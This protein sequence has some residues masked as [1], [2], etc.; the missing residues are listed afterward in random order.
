MI[1]RKTKLRRYGLIRVLPDSASGVAAVC[2]VM[3]AFPL[4]NPA[5]TGN[6]AGRRRAQA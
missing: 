6:D 5:L 1:A 4:G 2:A 3:P